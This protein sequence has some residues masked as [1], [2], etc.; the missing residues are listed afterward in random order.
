MSF[1]I[2]TDATSDLPRKFYKPNFKVIPMA[3]TVNGE[4]YDG[5]AK[6]IEPKIFYDTMRG[7][8]MPTT[9][10]INEFQATE[11]FKPLLAEGHNILHICFSSA[12]SGSY[13][14]V[15]AAAD[16]LAKEF[17]ER[18]LVVLDS[19]SASLGEALAVY[20]VLQKREQGADFDT[21]V[22]YAKEI[23]NRNAHY[24]TVDDLFHLY[25]GGRVS[26][27]QAKFGTALD[28]KPVL[29]VSPE[30]KLIPIS[31][32]KGRKKSLLELV[33]KFGEKHSS[34][35]DMIFIGHGDCMEDAEFVAKK[36]E[37]K[38]GYSNIEIG[39]IGEVIGSHSGAGTIALFFLTDERVVEA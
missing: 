20:Y 32:V 12:L 35:Q 24:F 31:K 27:M 25:R 29:Y 30:G 3:Y 17:P 21:C 36:I 11:F 8:A 15:K 38:Y 7:G 39:Y 28:L 9:S 26:K 1:Y 18:K 22:E 5:D 19:K 13:N 16:E 37:E 10:L 14:C 2:T 4:E 23:L 33:N 6:K 34:Q